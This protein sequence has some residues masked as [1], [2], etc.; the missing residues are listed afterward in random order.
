M[1]VVIVK[2]ANIKQIRTQLSLY[3][4]EC[5]SFSEAWP[6]AF[7]VIAI[8]FVSH[9]FVFRFQERMRFEQMMKLI[10]D[11]FSSLFALSKG[12]FTQA[13][14]VAATRCNFCRA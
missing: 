3:E 9:V 4:I 10:P 7:I 13:I 8:P 2:L 14:F 5:F 12:P 11:V 1:T 6:Q